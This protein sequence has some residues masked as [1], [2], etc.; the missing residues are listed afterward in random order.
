MKITID[1]PPAEA[2]YLDGPLRE[3]ES[4][5]VVEFDDGHT[6]TFKAYPRSL[7]DL[8]ETGPDTEAD[9]SAT[10]LGLMAREGGTFQITFKGVRGVE[11]RQPPVREEEDHG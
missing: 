11:F 6:V 8:N 9:F 10:G 4:D 2:P 3:P 5:V 7:L 1:M